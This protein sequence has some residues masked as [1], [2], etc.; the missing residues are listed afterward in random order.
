[1]TWVAVA[2]TAFHSPA[3]ASASL[4]IPHPQ[5]ILLSVPSSNATK[6][7]NHI[8]LLKKG[9][10]GKDMGP[11]IGVPAL[12]DLASLVGHNRR[13]SANYC[14]PCS[15]VCGLIRSRASIAMP[16]PHTCA[17]EA[18][19]SQ[20]ATSAAKLNG[21]MQLESVCMKLTTE[22]QNPSMTNPLR[23][24]QSCDQSRSCWQDSLSL[25]ALPHHCQQLKANTWPNTQTHW[26][27][28][29]DM[30]SSDPLPLAPH[31]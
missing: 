20:H 3:L 1:M 2:P 25:L 13:K 18:L 5:T 29:G 26:P 17:S 8:L 24:E 11:W 27:F 10:F 23:P 21:M 28:P 19:K 6:S 12:F 4:P 15:T 7:V 22:L 16:E 9:L 30:V 14:G 31:S